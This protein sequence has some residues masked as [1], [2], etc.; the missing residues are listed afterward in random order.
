MIKEKQCIRNASIGRKRYR[1]LLIMLFVLDLLGIAGFYYIKIN[2]AIPGELSVVAGQAASFSFSVPAS[3]DVYKAN[4]EEICA[5]VDLRHP[6]SIQ[7]V[8]Q[9]M[10]MEVSLFG[11]FPFK[12]VTVNV[13]NE[14]QVVAAG[15]PIGIY[16]RTQGVMVVDTGEVRD[17]EKGMIKPSE[18]IMKSGDYILKVNGEAVASRYDIMS[19]L[20]HLKNDKVTL[21]IHRDESEM[22]VQIT[23]AD[24]EDGYKLGIWIRDDM[25]GI[26]TLTYTKNLK[27]GALGH[28]ITDQDTGER[29]ALSNST[30][31]QA[32]I[33]NIKKGQEGKPGEL[34]GMISYGDAFAIGTIEKNTGQGIFGTLYDNVEIQGEPVDIAYKQDIREGTA[35]IHSWISG[36]PAD[37]EIKIKKVNLGKSDSSKGLEIEVTDEKLIALTGGIVQG[38]SGSPILQDGRLIGAVTHVFVNDPKKGYG[39]FIEEMLR[40]SQKEE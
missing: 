13:V 22:E 16:V 4:S 7:S 10:K 18:H 19:K 5:Q 39:I 40:Q 25:Q 32:T 23:C 6:F 34:G 1:L 33:L 31:Y 12:T 24:T 38:M 2:N 20:R 15:I 9:P 27:Y 14:Q 35:Y 30:L 11:V 26:G 17:R 8:G 29:V 28:S 37:Y 21:L 36:E 3:A